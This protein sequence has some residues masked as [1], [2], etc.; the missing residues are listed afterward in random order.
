MCSGSGEWAGARAKAEKNRYNWIANEIRFDRC[1]DTWARTIFQG[2][3]RYRCYSVYSLDNSC[4]V[5]GPDI[6]RV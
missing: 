1:Y 2:M 5:H 6:Y 3:R 4:K